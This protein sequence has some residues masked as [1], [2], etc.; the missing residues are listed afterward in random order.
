M[1]IFER[2]R[3]RPAKSAAPSRT[4]GR[5]DSDAPAS[6]AVDEESIL[7][8]GRELLDRSARHR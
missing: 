8:L 5:V 6:A 3:S 2:F 4:A 1:G 7:E